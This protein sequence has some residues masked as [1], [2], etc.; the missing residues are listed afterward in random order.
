[1]R[2]IK[3]IV[4]HC[5][6]TPRATRRETIE[7][8]WKFELGWKKPGYHFMIDQ[9]GVNHILLDVNHIAN[10]VKG[11]NRN[12]IH[13]AYIGGLD[14]FWNCACTLT[15]RQSQTLQSVLKSLKN[16]FPNA[17][18]LGHRDLSFDKNKDGKITPD[19][20]EKVCPC[21]DVDRFLTAYNI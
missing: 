3:Y 7:N 13:V 14:E 5:T 16:Q 10:G 6:G 21:F 17:K 1:M 2:E 15:M 11:C 8:N 4:V 20:W 9:F 12:A 18:I 19:E